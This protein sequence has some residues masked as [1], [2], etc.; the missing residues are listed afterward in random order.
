MSE[1]AL[2]VEAVVERPT[3]VRWGVICLAGA[4]AIVIY[5][6]RSCIAAAST[7]IEAELHFDDAQ[8]G[9]IK[10][11]F[12][13]GYFFQFVGAALNSRF[14]NRF[15]LVGMA[16]ASSIGMLGVSVSQTQGEF[17][18][19]MACIGLAQ[20][21]II[22]CV[23]QVVRDWIPANRRAAAGSIFTGCMS[24]GAATASGVTGILLSRD[25]AWRSAFLM[26]SAL[27]V[28]W[29][30][31]FG[32]WFRDRARQHAQ[33][34][35][36]ELALIEAGDGANQSPIP[37]AT[38]EVWRGMLTCRNQWFNCLQ[39][40][41]RNFAYTF[42]ITW[43]PAFL[44]NAYG[45]TK[46]EAG[47][48]NMVPLVCTFAGILIGGQLIDAILARTGNRYLSRS[49]TSGVG[50]LLC[51]ASIL[52]ASAT[53]HPWMAAGLIGLGM[54]FFGNASPATWAVT[55]DIAG[56]YTT[57]F[58]ALM[59]AIGVIA[60][61]ICPIVVGMMTQRI[62]AGYGDWSHVLYLF[63]AINVCAAICWLSINSKY[64]AKL[65]EVADGLRAVET[66]GT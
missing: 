12:S 49:V 6:H 43:Y 34:N 27:G 33:V 20:A 40:F 29:A 48:M 11:A 8:M 4:L 63:G 61:F 1:A 28:I 7:T 52:C 24:L 37:R 56:R 18:G 16:V 60:G 14:G 35:A 22:P 23:G 41:F 25:V 26:Y 17:F 36:A 15:V 38:A 51:A 47:F 65:P 5:I 10:A 30:L 39:Q 64:P 66:A 62:K 44:E 55:M 2:P 31:A 58:F 46:Q 53:P 57:L 54:M 3:F 45:V 50:H 9:W 19:Y 21:G 32:W 59:N 13:F 42:F